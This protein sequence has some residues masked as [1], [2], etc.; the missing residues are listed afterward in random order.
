[1][2]ETV[3]YLMGIIGGSVLVVI[4]TWILVLVHK[5]TRCMKEL[6]FELQATNKSREV[7]EKK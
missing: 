6:E 4:L 1:M 7:K 2:T 3:Q 5:Q